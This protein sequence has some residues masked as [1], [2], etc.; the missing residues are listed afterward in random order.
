VSRDP[1]ESPPAAPAPPLD[2]V[3]PLDALRR[4]A[5]MRDAGT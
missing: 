4:R 5:A 2:N 3:T 1:A